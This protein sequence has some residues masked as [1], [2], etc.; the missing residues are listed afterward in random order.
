MSVISCF[1]IGIRNLAYCCYDKNNKKILSWENYD[2]VN[3]SNVNEVNEKHV[4]LV[5]S[6]TAKYSNDEKYYCTKHTLKPI[7]KD[8]SGNILKK[9]PNLSVIKEITKQSGKKE[10]LYEYVR[11]NYSLI[12]IKKGAI[13]KSFDIE[14]LHDSIRKF[15][16]DRKDIFSK[17]QV[18]GLENQPVLK[19]PTMKTV[20]ILLYATLRD[21]L[22]PAIPKMKLIHALKKVSDKESG[23][24]GYADR[25]KA[26]IDRANIFLNE[27]KSDKKELFDKSLK[28][29]DLAD[30]L[31]MCLDYVF[32]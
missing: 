27:N 19:N 25:K 30:S 20:Q 23:D 16:I 3:D 14:S 5:C 22:A 15:V 8:L 2:L 29:A 12:I 26:S 28:K 13:K 24:K 7:F 21:I 1:D 18:I 10:D 6:K 11:K 31:C 9:M 17:S 4:C 32:S